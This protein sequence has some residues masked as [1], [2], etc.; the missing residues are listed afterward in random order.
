M[1]VVHR[2]AFAPFGAEQ[3]YALVNDVEAYPEFLPWCVAAVVLTAQ[4]GLMQARLTVKK[5]LLDYAFTTANRLTPGR[6]ISL[7]LIEG[8]F[9]KFNGAWQFEPVEGGCLIRFDVEFEFASRLL[10]AALSTAFKPLADSL[11]DAFKSRAY[12]VYEC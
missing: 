10:G 5:G 1:A 7:K 11:V 6:A 3:M 2:A 8:P 4:D 12:A 9:K